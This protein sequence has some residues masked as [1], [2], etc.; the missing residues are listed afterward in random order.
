MNLTLLETPKT[1]FLA[2][3]PIWMHMAKYCKFE[4]F[5]ENF[6]LANIVNTHICHVKIRDFGMIY[7]H[8]KGKR[9]LPF[10][11]VYSRETP[12]RRTFVKI[13]LRKNFQIQYY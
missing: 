4:S 10:L 3:M 7:L 12:Y 8:S 6:I 2:M 13:N 5:R 1:G 9:V 11:R